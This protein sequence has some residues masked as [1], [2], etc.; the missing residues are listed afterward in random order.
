MTIA[1]LISLLSL[2][3]V[4]L[5]VT[6]LTVYGQPGFDL[7]PDE[8]LTPSISDSDLSG[9]INPV[10][11]T[12]SI[13]ENKE[14]GF[15]FDFPA[16]WHQTPTPVVDEVL[17]TKIQAPDPDSKTSF[18]VNVYSEGYQGPFNRGVK[19]GTSAQ[20]Y[21]ANDMRI[22]QFIYTLMKEEGLTNNISKSQATSV[23][24]KDD[25]WRVEYTTSVSGKQVSSDVRDFVLGDNGD[26]YILS[27][28][29]GTEDASKTLPTGEKIMQSFRFTN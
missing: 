2:G 5:F 11:E 1:F 16:D 27:F 7:F 13:Y 18:E 10:N 15:A 9:V 8:P 26:L 25:A 4:I 28:T 12:T 17:T 23:A 29:T 22:L 14:R 3:L 6:P 24:G 20:E 19:N 21:A